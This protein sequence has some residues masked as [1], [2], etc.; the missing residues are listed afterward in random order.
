MSLV[1]PA[2]GSG[3]IGAGVTGADVTG[4]TVGTG[5]GEGV[6]SGRVLPLQTHDNWGISLASSQISQW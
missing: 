1:D 5:V 4:A 2:V 6:G 3:V